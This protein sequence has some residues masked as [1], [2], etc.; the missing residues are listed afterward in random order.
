MVYLETMAANAGMVRRAF[1]AVCTDLEALLW[2]RYDERL[3]SRAIN[4]SHAVW[5]R[6]HMSRPLKR[7]T[8]SLLETVDMSSAALQCTDFLARTSVNFS[9]SGDRLSKS[10]KNDL[11]NGRDERRQDR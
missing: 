9:A 4:C 7:S 2:S 5:L 1:S 3:S 11:Q 10:Q 8:V 6:S